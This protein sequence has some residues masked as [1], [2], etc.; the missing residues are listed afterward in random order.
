M[1]KNLLLLL[2][3]AVVAAAVSLLTRTVSV[4]AEPPPP[5]NAPIGTVIAYAGTFTPNLESWEK[6]TGWMLC[7]GRVLD[8]TQTAY[9]PLFDA[10]GSSWGGDGANKFNVPDLEGYFLRGV[11]NKSGRDKNAAQRTAIKPGGHSGDD[12]GTIEPYATAKPETDF[13]TDTTGKHSHQDPTWNGVSGTAYELATLY[14]AAGGYDYIPSQP[15]S[16]AGEHNHKIASGGDKET[17]P[18]NASVY[19][20]IRVQ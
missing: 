10:I 13:I 16:E 19:W 18:I 5:P 8:R 6:S 4:G 20:I 3:V 11:D 2:A 12:V 9:K 1:K 14:R 7:N 15:T 17:R